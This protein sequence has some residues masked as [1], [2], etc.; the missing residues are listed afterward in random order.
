MT[1]IQAMGRFSGKQVDMFSIFQTQHN[2][3]YAQLYCGFDLHGKGDALIVGT[4]G[5][6]TIHKN[7]WN[8]VKATIDYLD[9][10]TIELDVPFTAGG[11]NYE[12]EHFCDLIRNNKTESPIITHELSRQMIAMLEEARMQIGLKFKG[13]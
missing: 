10:R 11:L 12:I 6:I 4:S 8:P 9:G 1:D 5:H 2:D 13:E 7:W 3:G